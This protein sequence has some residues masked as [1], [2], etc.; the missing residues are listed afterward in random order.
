[1]EVLKTASLRRIEEKMEGM[2]ENSVRYCVLQKA[3]NF[4]S[5]WIELGQALY[6]VYNDKLYKEWGYQA[7]ETYTVKEAGIKKPTA[8]KLLNSYYF[9]EK[10][11]SQ[12]LQANYDGSSDVKSMSGYEAVDVLRLA[13]R[14]KELDEADYADLKKGA[15]EEGKDAKQLK[16]DVT[17]LLKKRKNIDPEEEKIRSNKVII[18]RCVTTLKTIKKDIEILGVLPR[19]IAVEIGKLLEKIEAEIS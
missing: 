1:M 9:L 7:F 13:K 4:K 11:E 2:D 17:L 19:H 14:N 15:F 12:C 3:K 10:E 16:K 18:K 6:S 5:S 8:M